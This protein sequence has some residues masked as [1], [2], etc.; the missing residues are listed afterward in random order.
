MPEPARAK[1]KPVTKARSVFISYARKD[2]KQ[3]AE[4][5]RDLLK[6][7]CDVW[8][9]VERVPGGSSWSKEIE[10]ALN[11]CDVLLAVLTPESFISEICRAERIWALDEGKRVIAILAVANAPVPLYLKGLNYRQ[12]PNQEVELL[13]DLS[14][15]PPERKPRPVLYDTIPSL[16]QN[17]V[18]REKA[19]SDLR[20]LVF[21][22][23]AGSNIA[24]TAL[25]GMAGI[26]KTVLATALCRDQVV[27]RAFPDG[28]AW[29]TIGREYAGDFVTLMREVARAL[30]D[31]LSGYDNKLACE[32]R[33]RTVLREKAALVVVD[34]VWN[35]EHLKPLL[36]DSPRS[37]FL[38]TTRDAGIANL[39]A[40][41]KYSANLLN[42]VEGRDLLTLWSGQENLPV[43]AGQIIEACG[44]LAGAISQIGFCLRA[45]TADGRRAVSVSRD[46][47]LKMWDLQSG[48]VI[49]A[50]TCDGN[51]QCC[52]VG[53]SMILAGDAGGRLYLLKLEE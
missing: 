41:R 12:Y 46:S 4:A 1:S 31:D 30:G 28:I 35:L 7:S 33:Y 22:E 3:T 21:T 39:V 37:R 17:F 53:D 44:E 25:A 15:A 23:G 40:A 45:V 29:I 5:L 2:G 6:D 9:D 10:A 16:P 32:N 47:T 52:A 14:L 26:G 18:V 24:V 38:F 49:A 36:V 51:A 8:Q 50:F 13:A 43:N 19:L 34:D 48:S 11:T 27:Q 20:D 42:R